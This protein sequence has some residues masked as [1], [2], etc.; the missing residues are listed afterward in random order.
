MKENSLHYGI[1]LDNDSKI[2]AI[3][4]GY[5][6]PKTTIK[7]IQNIFIQ[8]GS[9]LPKF[10]KMTLNPKDVYNLQIEKCPLDM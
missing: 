6:C 4:F 5:L 8:R 2:E 9:E 1:P 10:Y 7:T 3:Y